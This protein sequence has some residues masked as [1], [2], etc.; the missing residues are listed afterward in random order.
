MEKDKKK[1]Y[2]LFA[3]IIV[4]F[5][6]RPALT[7]IG[8]LLKL[9]K[10]DMG[11][12]DTAAGFL[13]TI[14]MLAF[15]VFSPA[16]NLLN[17]KI[18]TAN[19]LFT[20]FA[21]IILGIIL[22]SYAGL[23]GLW[24]GTLLMGTGISFGNVIIPAIIKSEF[25]NQYGLVT[26]CNSVALA[27]SSGIASG[28]NYPLASVIGWKNMLCVWAVVALIGISLWFPVRDIQVAS[29]RKSKNNRLVKNKT[30]WM[31]TIFLGIV[32][33]LFYS[34][35]TWLA[36]IFQSKGLSAE[37]AGYYVSAFQMTGVLS[38]FLIPAWAGK[39]RDQRK[40]TWLVLTIF[41]T[42]I[43]LIL[44]SQNK[45]LLLA[46]ALMSGFSCNGSFALSVPWRSY[47]QSGGC[48]AAFSNEPIHR[49]SDC[50]CRTSGNGLYLQYL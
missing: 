43:L 30:A 39:S 28:I 38:S 31:V 35:M 26:A 50:R 23:A 47:F 34:I 21:F 13:T 7:G 41:L 2:L 9:I 32:S 4:G 15:A 37:T 17:R 49:L 19:T 42:G 18:G 25:P 22:R 12:S 14:P 40:V 36:T 8:S 27:V 1:R 29:N 16:A 24:A 5:C 11:L 48:G 10:P 44:L 45:A 46:G 6:M 20:G 33:L 3:I